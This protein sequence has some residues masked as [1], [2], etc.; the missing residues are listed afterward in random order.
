MLLKNQRIFR[1]ANDFDS[2]REN[3]SSFDALSVRS[4]NEEESSP[5]ARHR[6]SQSRSRNNQGLPSHP[7]LP[8]PISWSP[9]LPKSDKSIQSNNIAA[10]SEARLR[11]R[12]RILQ[13]DSSPTI[14]DDE[15]IESKLA[16]KVLHR[17]TLSR[18][19]HEQIQNHI[20][21]RSQTS[22]DDDVDHV[23]PLQS[24]TPS[25]KLAAPLPVRNDL[26]NF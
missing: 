16:I 12:N 6:S 26:F 5:P 17:D 4:S 8:P 2:I 15:P 9:S 13:R 3:G 14:N 23:I 1:P 19:K 22:F 20:R 24:R 11:R 7:P 10:P 18:H 25:A 21:K